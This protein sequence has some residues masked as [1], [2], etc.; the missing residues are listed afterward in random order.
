[1]SEPVAPAVESAQP[2]KPPRI[3][4]SPGEP[5]GV[6]AQ[7]A[8][9]SGLV[10]L[11]FYEVPARTGEI[12]AIHQFR[13]ANRRLRAAVELFASVIH[14]S[15]V[16]FLRRELHW[17]GAT[18]GASR[19][20]D[21]TE[22][23]MRDRSL[24]LDRESL[25]YLAPIFEAL[26]LMR[27]EEHSKIDEMFSSKRYRTLMERLASAPIRKLSPTTVV[28]EMAPAMFRPIARSVMRAGAKLE[29][30]SP[31]ELFHRL[32]IRI[33]R[34][35]YAFE[36]NEELAGKRGRKAVTR[37]AELQELLGQHHDAV[38]A[39]EWLRRF[40]GTS[41]APP[42]SLLAAG[43]LIQSLHR[44]QQKLSTRATR[45]WKKLEHT[46]IIG[47]TLA[48]VARNAQLKEQTSAV[49]AE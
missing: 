48:E 5:V 41:N 49:S 1:V 34:L 36:M 23:L 46:G 6:A 3:A 10:T 12:E 32:R 13:V 28:S 35:R 18:A 37:L 4:I 24:R 15:R 26:S 31:S 9:K 2:A 42:P 27:R 8:L 21:V 17:L 44:R 22:E 39:I 43:S 33:K 29:P 38:V 14:G 7:N 19:E 47:D 40:A 16:N 25:E 20:C 30:E 45:R 11:E